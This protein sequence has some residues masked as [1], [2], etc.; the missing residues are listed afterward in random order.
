[1]LFGGDVWLRSLFIVVDRGSR[2]TSGNNAVEMRNPS[3]YDYNWIT[4]RYVPVILDSF[5]DGVAEEHL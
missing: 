3:D 4:E 1:M 5:R 2:R